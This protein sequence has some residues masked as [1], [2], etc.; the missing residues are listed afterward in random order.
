MNLSLYFNPV[1]PEELDFFTSNER[2]NLIGNHLLIH[3]D[4]QHFPSLDTVKLAILGVPEEKNAYNNMGCSEAPDKL[5]KQFYQLFKH[6]EIPPIAD[7]GNLNGKPPT[8][9]T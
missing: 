8:I 4:E 5:R 1:I 3:T 7:L 2:N 9:H 6:Q